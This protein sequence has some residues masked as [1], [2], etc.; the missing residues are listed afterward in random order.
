MYI[1][2]Y[3]CTYIH[4]HMY[5][6]IYVYIYTHTHVLVCTCIP[7]RDDVLKDAVC[8]S[9]CLHVGVYACIVF[10]EFETITTHMSSAISRQVDKQTGVPI[11]T[12]LH[13]TLTQNHGGLCLTLH[14]TI[15]MQYL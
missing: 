4:V 5:M 8:A 12:Q 6:Y 11:G 15:K 3:I 2:T 9:V 7:A 14:K 10:V 1:C 13:A